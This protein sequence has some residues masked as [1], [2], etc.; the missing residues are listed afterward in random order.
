M[1]ITPIGPLAILPLTRTAGSASEPLPMERVERS[2][3]SEDETYSPSNGDS[4]AQ[5]GDQAQD[6]EL[7]EN[8]PLLEGESSLT[9]PAASK[10]PTFDSLHDSSARVSFF[11]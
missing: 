10:A 1:G 2:E 9:E 5:S 4:E 6:Y 8:G 11:A 3:R 7:G